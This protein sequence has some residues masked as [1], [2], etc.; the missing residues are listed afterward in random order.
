MLETIYNIYEFKN[1]IYTL[2]QSQ[3]T[4]AAVID[5]VKNHD[6]IF[7]VTMWPERAAED[8]IRQLNESNKLVYVHTVN[9]FEEAYNII[10]R[11]VYGL[12]TDY[13]Y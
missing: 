5:F 10:K 6:S 4:D 1:V 9:R 3:Q 7:A 13:L 12:Y 11:G 2:Y 8:F